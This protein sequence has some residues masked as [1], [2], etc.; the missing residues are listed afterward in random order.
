MHELKLYI[1]LRLKD[2]I[3]M[4]AKERGLSMNKMATQLLEIG[5]YKLLEEEKTYGQI[6]YKQADSK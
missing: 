2:R 4:L 3:K 1:N 5:I 6:K